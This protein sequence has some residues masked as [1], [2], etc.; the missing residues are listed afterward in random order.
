[1]KILQT[2]EWIDSM[3]KMSKLSIRV[4]N[5]IARWKVGNETC[6]DRL[7]AVVGIITATG[8]EYTGVHVPGHQCAREVGISIR[9]IM[10]LT[11]VA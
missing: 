10:P 8:H 6:H 9:L 7:F 3:D 11:R 2:P 1:M 4:E 5:E